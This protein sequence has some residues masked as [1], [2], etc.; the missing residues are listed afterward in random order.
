M[1]NFII[2]LPKLTGPTSYPF[3]KICVKSTLTLIIYS[4]AIFTTNDMLN[5]LELSQTTDMDKI[6]R[7]NFLNSQ[8]LAVLNSIL[9]DNLLMYDQPNAEAL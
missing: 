2:T 7:R 9:P 1:A 5:A 3:W 8:A 4:R 6:A